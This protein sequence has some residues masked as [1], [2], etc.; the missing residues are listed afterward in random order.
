[1]AR[2]FVTGIAGFIG[3][4][5]A[6]ALVLRGDEVSGI[7]DLSCGTL[8]NLHP[9]K[10]AITFIKGDIRDKALL[11]RA[12]ENVDCIF[13]QAAS[14]SNSEDNHHSS[15]AINITATS[16]LIE[17]A[18]AQSV[19]R[20]VFASSSAVYGPTS[21]IPYVETSPLR[22]TSLFGKQK[23]RAECALHEAWVEHG[24]E[25]VSLR[26]FSVFG[27]RQSSSAIDSGLVARLS[28][29]MLLP[30]PKTRP[31]IYGDGEQ[32]RDFVYI[33]DVVSMNLKVAAASAE[34]VAGKTFNVATGTVSSVNQVAEIIAS[35][36]GY[37][38]RV[39]HVPGRTGEI[40]RVVGDTARSRKVLEFTPSTNVEEDLIKTVDWYRFQAAKA[41][42]QSFRKTPSIADLQ[43]REREGLV[44]DLSEAV[45]CG[46]FSLVFQ[47]IISLSD[48]TLT[49]AEALV[50]WQNRGKY[51]EPARFISLAEEAGF[52]NQLGV[53]VVRHACQA[54][55]SSVQ[56]FGDR[57]RL[58]VNV[59][60]SQLE[61]GDLYQA[62]QAGLK[63]GQFN[64]NNLEIEI[65]E[66]V[67]IQHWAK[68]G[69]TL[70]LLHNL[71][72]SIALD[73]FGQGYSNLEG[74]SRLKV[75]RI[76]VDRS[77]SM[78][79]RTRLPVLDGILA[80]ANRLAISVVAEGVETRRELDRVRN[81]GCHEAQGRF[82]AKPLTATE[83]AD[84]PAM[85][86]H[87]F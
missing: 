26:Y 52:I 57:F 18:L 34:L 8:D 33:D 15:E 66:R 85:I 68:V 60:P 44:D 56:L 27:P 80:L 7:D 13:H 20:I 23:M 29:L 16:Y 11:N 31:E 74:L 84:V 41:P 50:R 51:I 25:T 14:R 37:S 49:G 2:Y 45:K 9:L 72:V 65:T 47:P 70:D 3:A 48:G 79:G 64:A 59:S 76:K 61:S 35:R 67:C 12:C 21:A 40:R 86:K 54:I 69:K 17:A 5:I 81:A 78:P 1:M 87:L 36:I 62:I 30:H 38:G 24:L 82:I 4:S 46:N 73:D 10:H 19:R 42:R 63:E 32:C 58:T 22:P 83:L 28:E 43:K 75:S 71:G 55:A 77:I 53:W 6:R 39:F